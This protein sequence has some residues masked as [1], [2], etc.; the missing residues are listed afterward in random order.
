MS[1]QEAGES[2]RPRT[3]ERRPQEE[4]RFAENVQTTQAKLRADSNHFHIIRE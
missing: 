1:P 3:L 4:K 2:A